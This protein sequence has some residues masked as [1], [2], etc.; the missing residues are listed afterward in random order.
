MGEAIHLYVVLRPGMALT[1]EAI[2]NWAGEQLERY[3]LPDHVHFGASL[4]V[5][6]T[7]KTDRRAL[8]KFLQK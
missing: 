3:K 1:A 5:G 7:G 4:P 6:G 8:R 2:R